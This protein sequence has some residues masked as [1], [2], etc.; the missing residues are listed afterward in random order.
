M[1]F[2]HEGER[3]LADKD[4]ADLLPCQRAFL[5]SMREIPRA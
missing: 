3:V 5:D 4:R 1:N 2:L